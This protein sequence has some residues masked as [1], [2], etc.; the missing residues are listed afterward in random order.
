[1]ATTTTLVIHVPRLHCPRF[2]QFQQHWQT[3]MMLPSIHRHLTKLDPPNPVP[4][5]CIN[6]ATF[7]NQT[8]N[9]NRTISSRISLFGPVVGALSVKIWIMGL[10]RTMIFWWTMWMK[11]MIHNKTQEQMFLRSSSGS[12]NSNENESKNGV[13]PLQKM[14]S[15]GSGS[16]ARGHASSSCMHS[17]FFHSLYLHSFI[18]SSSPWPFNVNYRRQ[19]SLEKINRLG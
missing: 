5:T 7:L 15:K 17:Q 9:L 18:H 12:S 16:V 14:K 11:P 4:A 6:L 1:M 3:R 13:I 2:F 19:P 10:I 8:K